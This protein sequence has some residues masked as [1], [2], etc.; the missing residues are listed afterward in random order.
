MSDHRQASRAS[1]QQQVGKVHDWAAFLGAPFARRPLRVPVQGSA[2]GRFVP[3]RRAN[4]VHIADVSAFEAMQWMRDEPPKPPRYAVASA[5]SSVLIVCKVRTK[6]RGY[7]VP[8]RRQA[9][10][11]PVPAPFRLR[12][13]RPSSTR[14]LWQLPSG[15][16]Q[17]RRAHPH[18]L[19]IILRFHRS[20]HLL[21]HKLH[22]LQYVWSYAHRVVTDF[23]QAGESR[24]SKSCVFHAPSKSQWA[25]TIDP[26]FVCTS[27]VQP[28]GI[29]LGC[30]RPSLYSP[31]GIADRQRIVNRFGSDAQSVVMN[32]TMSYCAPS[33]AA[34]PAPISSASAADI[35]RVNLQVF[36]N[37]GFRQ[38]QREV[39]LA[40]LSNKDC[41]V[42]MP[43]GA[44]KSLT[45]QLPAMC[46]PGLTVVISP[47]ISLIYDQV[48]SLVA[49][50]IPAF[51]LAGELEWDVIRNVFDDCRNGTIKLLYITPEKIQSSAATKNLFVELAQS[52]RLAR[53]VVDESHCVSQW[54]FDFRESYSRL[55]L[56]KSDFPRV[57]IM[58]LTATATRAVSD[59]IVNVLR[60]RGCAVFRQSFNRTNLFYEVRRKGSKA[61]TVADIVKFISEKGYMGESG[62]VYC[63]SKND[64]EWVAAELNRRNVKADFYHAG[65][66]PA[67]RQ[68]AQDRWS[69]GYVDVICATV[70]FG[71]GIN[72]KNVRFVIHFTMSKSPEAYYQESGR[73]GRDGHPSHCLLYYSLLDRRRAMTLLTEPDNEGRSRNPEQVQKDLRLLD[74]MTDFCENTCDCRR[75]LMLEYF[76]EKFDPAKCQGHCDNC[77]RGGG[78]VRYACDMTAYA[79]H[80]IAIVDYL[81]RRND[82]KNANTVAQI[83]HGSRAKDIV[84]FKDAIASYGAGVALSL[85]DCTRLIAHLLSREI[86]CEE[87]VS[88]GVMNGYKNIKSSIKLHRHAQTIVPAR[89][90]VMNFWTDYNNPGSTTK[91]TKPSPRTKSSSNQQH[92]VNVPQGQSDPSTDYN[93]MGPTRRTTPASKTG[94]STSQQ[95]V[96]VPQD[97]TSVGLM[98]ELI[99]IRNVLTAS[100]QKLVATEQELQQMIDMRAMSVPDIQKCIG[101]LKGLR[102]GNAF[103]PVLQQYFSRQSVDRPK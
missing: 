64:C 98:A 57:P 45:Y 97:H 70:A 33:Y 76:D 58:A 40:A 38:N 26:V 4:N 30:N 5:A 32:R 91:R 53:F 62:I 36:G 44:G 7:C 79:N 47:L 11:H 13:R 9:G 72:K 19:A 24:T 48:Q 59:D 68:S 88:F 39:V 2:P 83:F 85:D 65:S 55:S 12:R 101:I 63:L 20:R 103:L 69:K 35:D 8:T 100:T 46:S 16:P 14:L 42:L 95:P 75:S 96:Q 49:L 29:R 80:I 66:D 73:A 3:R 94:S 51:A 71:M 60:I 61:S 34:L 43:T 92:P 93:T 78:R 67:Q 82:A 87:V 27:V 21:P 81:Q 37:R 31:V 84:A 77:Q 74:R 90:I 28:I 99:K 10:M 25:D 86:L 6:F 41:F 17:F 15:R 102:F 56:L 1:L 22:R 89:P 50:N 52:G 23:R 18:R 54:G